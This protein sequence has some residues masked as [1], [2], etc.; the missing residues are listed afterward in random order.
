MTRCAHRGATVA[1][2]V[3]C[4]SA[5]TGCADAEFEADEVRMAPAV[6]MDTAEVE[7]DIAEV[8]ILE[9]PATGAA[10]QPVRT[11]PVRAQPVRARPMQ[12]PAAATE[13]AAVVHGVAELQID[14][15]QFVP[16][17]YLRA[18]LRGKRAVPEALTSA[19]GEFFFEN[20]PPG[21]YELA[22][23]TVAKNARQVY[24]IP[25]EIGAGER[26]R[27]PPVHIPIDSVKSRK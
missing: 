16:A 17:D 27:L 23:L 5:A 24:A 21:T 2:L 14:E 15:K 4:A 3:G 7:M 1:L 9:S 26:V 8:E 22:F 20:V 12:L 11:Q 25:V 18:V 13:M 10:P 6:E 19:G